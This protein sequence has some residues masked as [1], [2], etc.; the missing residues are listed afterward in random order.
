MVS[1]ALALPG[2]TLTYRERGWPS[3]RPR[4]S[5]PAPGRPGNTLLR[6]NSHQDTR[7]T[8]STHAAALEVGSVIISHFTDEE[9]EAG[10]S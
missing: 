3:L 9:V 10:W 8:S 2:S 7:I 4:A 6:S 5:Q 1:G